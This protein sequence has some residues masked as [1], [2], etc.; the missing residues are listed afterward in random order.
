M[1]A[2]VV[3]VVAPCRNDPAGMAQG[4]EEMFVEAFVHA[5]LDMA[6]R[7]GMVCW[8]SPWVG[9]RRSL[10]VQASTPTLR[11][12]DTEVCVSEKRIRRLFKETLTLWTSDVRTNSNLY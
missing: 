6:L 8:L 5:W 12:A 9:S 1:R 2:V 7:Y 4:L 11:I 3:V 10:L